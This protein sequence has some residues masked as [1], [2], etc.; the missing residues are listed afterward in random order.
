MV[1][2]VGDPDP[3]VVDL[4]EGTFTGDRDGFKVAQEVTG[5]SFDVLRG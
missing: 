4:N 5:S 2:W 1:V 3:S